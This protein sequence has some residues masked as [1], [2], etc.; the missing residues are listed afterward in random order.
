MTK[1]FSCKILLLALTIYSCNTQQKK[2]N[3]SEINLLDN[4]ELSTKTIS[5]QSKY[6]YH[7]LEIGLTKENSNHQSNYLF[8]KAEV[9]YSISK[10]LQESI[11]SLQEKFPISE[12]DSKANE[13]YDNLN[14]FKGNLLKIDDEFS[15]IYAK[16]IFRLTTLDDPK[17]SSKSDFVSLLSKS[18]EQDF[19]LRLSKLHNSISLLENIMLTHFNIASSNPVKVIFDKFAGLVSQSSKRLNKGDTLEI[20]AGVGAFSSA[21]NPQ[22]IINGSNIKVGSDGLAKYS[23]K[24]SGENGMNVVPVYIEFTSPDGTKQNSKIPIVYYVDN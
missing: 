24:V 23:F 4:L 17:V 13:L 11:L 8:P 2:S 12:S 3:S 9:N 1:L 21:S 7:T 22:I 6:L 10:N 5:E 16:S 15:K 19:K 18:N 14:L 20:S